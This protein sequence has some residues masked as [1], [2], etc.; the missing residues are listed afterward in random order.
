MSKILLVEPNFPIPAKSK[1]H[2]DFLPV[3]LL[4]LASFHRNKGDEIKLIRGNQ[5]FDDFYPSQIKITSLFTYWS[6][7]VWDSVKFYKEAY[8][9]AKI[10]VG[11]IYA[12]LMPEHCKQSGCDEVFVGV[13]ERV[14][15]FKP[16]YDLVD[17]DYQIAHTSR[18][19]LRKCKFCGTWKI[20][21]EFISKKSIKDEICSNRIIFYDNNLLANPHI[22][23]IL[24]ELKN[25]K[26]N[27]RVVYSESQCGIDGRL[28]TSE[29]AKLLKQ[30]RFLNPRIAWDHGY[31]QKKMIKKQIDMLVA[32]GYPR[33]E[34][35][36]FMIY[37]FEQDYHEM[38]KKLNQCQR[39]GVQIA[40]CRYRPLNQISEHYNPRKR[41]MSDEY[42]IHPR[43]T[44]RQIKLFRRRVRRQNIKVRHGFSFYSKKL[45][46]LGARKKRAE[47][48]SK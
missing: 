4:K 9:K 27:G 21:P 16:A 24:E 6:N 36:I 23:E 45:E 28:L 1:N 25:A 46:R 8:P 3:G 7:Y 34:I 48:M 26:H 11:G 37:N 43:W 42:Y 14:E 12:S 20:E 15:K 35:Y 19:C 10:V 13:D 40:D 30:A 39:W 47:L 18:G 31:S 29:V 38:V 2:R 41:Q 22:K 17:V 32:A 5:Y 44:D 33:K